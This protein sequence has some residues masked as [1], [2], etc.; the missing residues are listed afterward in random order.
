M[1]SYL[2]ELISK[3]NLAISEDDR[4]KRLN[5]L[6]K[7]LSSNEEVMALAYKK[8][9]CL[10]DFE[11]ALKHFGENSKELIVAQRKLYEAKLALDLHPLVNEYNAAYK[12]VRK[13]YDLINKELFK[14]FSYMGGYHD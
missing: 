14:D 4:V 3:L 13:I 12:E 7:K 9:M 10:I 5:E 11:D 6:D 8:D 1:T 2:S